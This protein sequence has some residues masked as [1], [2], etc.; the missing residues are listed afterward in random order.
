MAA[1][2]LAQ[3]D[4]FDRVGYDRWVHRSVGKR[5]AR[6]AQEAAGHVDVRWPDSFRIFKRGFFEANSHIHWQLI[7]AVWVP[8]VATLFALSFLYF[9]HSVLTVLGWAGLGLLIWT[10]AEYC[11][12]RFV[13]HYVPRSRLGRRLHF[14]LHGIHHL[15]PWDP[16]RLLF[17]PLLGLLIGGVLFLGLW[18]LL[19]LPLAVPAFAGLLV[20][21]LLY[22]LT[23]YYTHHV[24]PRSRWGKFLKA[25]HLEH[26]HKTWEGMYGVSSPLWDLV[27]R[28]GRK[29]RA[30]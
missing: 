18:A 4:G 6:Q 21:Y 5:T 19:P 24:K 2:L 1:P 8:I 13:F 20:G 14:L 3:V 25:W 9:G 12:H 17:P 27:F 11:L 7:L 10:F 30:K 15:D 16:T 22:D 29:R 26:H 23:H 28:T